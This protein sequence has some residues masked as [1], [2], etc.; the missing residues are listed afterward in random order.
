MQLFIP[1][2]GDTLT[3]SKDWTFSVLNEYRNVSLLA[4]MDIR[5]PHGSTYVDEK[6]DLYRFY[7]EHYPNVQR[8]PCTL[9]KGVQ[10]R[11]DRIYIRK[12][13]RDFDS[14]SFLLRNASVA[15][16]DIEV[17]NW[18]IDGRT[19]RPTTHTYREPKKQVRF[20]AP[21]DDV[22]RMEIVL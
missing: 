16:Y 18:A 4:Y 19:R 10:L 12:G 6:K 21:L 3:L 11:V 2:L 8:W 15:G 14:V 5:S 1:R 9:G 17:T 7:R 22:N 20:F 13:A